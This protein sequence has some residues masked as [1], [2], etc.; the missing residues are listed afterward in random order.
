MQR[1]AWLI[2]FLRLLFYT[3]LLASGI[4][5]AAGCLMVFHISQDLPKLPSPLSRIIETPQSLIYAEDGQVLIALGEK[6]SVSLDMVSSDFL[7]AIVA[8]E[9]HRFF[10]HH[11]VNK[12]RTFKALYITLF[13]PGQIQGASTITQQLAKNLFFSFEKT[14]HR[15]IKE[16]L[17]AFQIEQANTKEQILEAYINQ[18]HFGA[19]AQGIEKAARMYFD[20]PAQDL[21]LAEASLLA[22]LPKSPT[23]YNPFRYYDRALA[24]RHVVLGRM[25]AAGFITADEAA[26]TD[27]IRPELHDGRKDA[28]TGSYFLDALIAELVDIYGEDVVYHGGIKV[29]STMDSRRQAD[30]LTAVTEGMARLDKLMGLD[31]GEQ[32]KPQAALVA[33][34]TSSGAVKAMVGGR[35]YYAS[36]YNR[37]VNSKRQAGSGFKPFLYYAAFRDEKLNP[38]SVFQ[39][40]PVAIPIKGAPDWYPQNFEKT[41]RGPMILKLG[42]IHSVNTIAA[43]LV[44]DVG[45]DAV[46]DVARACGVKSPLKSVY[47]VALG[48]SEVSVMDMASGFSTLAGLGIYHEPFLF[49]RVEDAR[50]RVL[51]E[52]IVKDRRVLD[53]ATAFQV[54]DMM[55]GVVDLGSGKGVR[56]LGFNRP[57]AG[58]TGTTNDCND[59]WFTGFTPSL[60]VSVWTGYDKKKQLIDKN[61]RG[62]TGGRGAVPIWTDFMIR[63]MKGEPE[64]DFFIPADIRYETVETTTGC[65]AASRQNMAEETDSLQPAAD[66]SDVIRVALKKDQH[67]CREN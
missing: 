46:V 53:M 9:D 54:V 18:I 22:G 24:R 20:K 41:F 16:L 59:A 31:E 38:A 13:K 14:W 15:K 35:D 50:G 28:R 48:A 11:G 7:N 67:P 5:A 25:V 44:A 1:F 23:Y 33:I 27:A 10:E 21:T 49:W 43:Q 37:A 63:A 39:D 2:F 17:V 61:R 45:P 55:E 65:P 3:G 57:A 4:M 51:F 19:G 34:D 26:Q 6:T 64:R 60:C 29:Y 58:K 32:E 40:M 47:S 30:A 56:S 42:L 62:I 66:S 8:T 36:E 12:L 52:H